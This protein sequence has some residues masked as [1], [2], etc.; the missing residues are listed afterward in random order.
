MASLDAARDVLAFISDQEILEVH[1]SERDRSLP[2]GFP[3]E[4][5]YHAP[6]NN[7]PVIGAIP[8]AAYAVREGKHVLQQAHPEACVSATTTMLI[9]DTIAR[10]DLSTLNPDY[11]RL[12]ESS[13]TNSEAAARTLREVFEGSGVNVHTTILGS[14][15][16]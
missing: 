6:S 5:L 15:S 4:L 14:R 3:L 1:V 13:G 2:P 7:S 16:K 9:L 8:K 10:Y 12:I 11:E